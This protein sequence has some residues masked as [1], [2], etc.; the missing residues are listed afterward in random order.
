VDSENIHS[1]AL[2]HED[3]PVGKQEYA[4]A[5]VHIPKHEGIDRTGLLVVRTV[6]WIIAGAVFIG[7]ALWWVMT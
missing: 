6:L 4:H 3:Q 5:H 1:E 2:G 7:F